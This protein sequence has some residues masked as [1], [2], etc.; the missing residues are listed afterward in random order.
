MK[1]GQ[2]LLRPVQDTLQWL[3][4]SAGRGTLL[5]LMFHLLFLGLLACW[6]LRHVEAPVP[7][8]TWVFQETREPFDN[9]DSITV[10]MGG[11]PDEIETVPSGWLVGD[12]STKISEPTIEPFGTTIPQQA[13][14]GLDA[15]GTGG[16]G[17]TGG[18]GGIGAGKKRPEYAVTKGSFTVWTAPKD[19][20][21][22]EDYQVIIEVQLP[23]QIRRY[24]VRDLS[25]EIIGT[26][27]WRQPIPGE[28]QGYVGVE[29][30]RARLEFRVPG[31]PR[32]VRDVVEVRSRILKEQ[33]TL[34]IVF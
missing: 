14:S 29:E 12:L 10:L 26:D 13:G 20:E 24:P 33:Q 6:T 17:A 3:S 18:T 30:N 31:A 34:K 7:L 5:S 16:G 27:G 4:S 11:I 2:V 22:G 9:L 1:T 23:A 8:S 19:P 25:G 15:S 21:P 32:L 28:K